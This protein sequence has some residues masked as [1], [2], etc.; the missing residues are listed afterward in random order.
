MSLVDQCSVIDSCAMDIKENLGTVNLKEKDNFKPYDCDMED[1]TT[2]KNK[3]RRKEKQEKLKKVWLSL[4]GLNPQDCRTPFMETK[5]LPS[6]TT[7]E[8]P[9]PVKVDMEIIDKAYHYWLSGNNLLEDSPELSF[10]GNLFKSLFLQGSSNQSLPDEL[11]LSNV[12]IEGVINS[13]PGVTSQKH[14]DGNVNASRLVSITL[15]SD[16]NFCL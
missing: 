9:V 14:S 15:R 8:D 6:E 12:N 13:T 2:V 5:Q 16:L 7:N 10:F 11:F 3:S 4:D 1:C